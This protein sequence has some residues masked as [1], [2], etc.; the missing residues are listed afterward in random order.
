MKSYGFVNSDTGKVVG[1]D[2]NNIIIKI[3]GVDDDVEISHD[4]FG[5]AFY[6]AYCIKV[7]KS[8]GITIEEPYTI[9]DW[10]DMDNRLKYVAMSRTTTAK[11]INIL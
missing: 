2:N 10:E 6:P 8:Q 5:K 9:H 3:D 4:H 1:F 11:H 7:H